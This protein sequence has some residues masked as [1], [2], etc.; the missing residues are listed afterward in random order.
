MAAYVLAHADDMPAR[1]ALSVLAPDGGSEDWNYDDLRRAVLG[2]AGALL[3]RG[4]QA[5]DRVLL[6][7]GNTVDFPICYLAALSVDI[8]PVPVSSQLTAA[9]LA[10]ILDEIAPVAILAD[11][12]LALPPTDGPVLTEEMLREMRGADPAVP[13]MGDPDRLGYIIY[14]SGTSGRPRAVMHAH[15]AVWA[16]RMMHADWCGLGPDDRLLHAGAFNWTY[17]LGTGLMDPWTVGATALIPAEG[18]P[19]TALPTLLAR[20]GATIFAAAPGVFRKLLKD[21]G[22]LDLP[23]LRH[24][25]SAGEK[26]PPA[27]ARAWQQATG[28]PIYEALGMSECSTFISTGPERPAAPDSSGLP[29]RG[30]RVAVVDEAGQ[31]LPRRTPGILA[32]DRD[33]PGMM[34]GYLGQPAETRDRFR[35]QWFLTGDTVLMEDC[36]SVRYLGR[37]D[38]MMN[39]GGYRVSPLEVEAAMSAH[40]AILEAAAFEAQVRA[41]ASVIALCYTCPPD[42]EAP[43]DDTLAAFAAERLAR[44]KCPRIF[45]RID[46]MPVNANGK[47]NRRALREDRKASQ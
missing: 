17:T 32:V 36:G 4:F 7:L 23:A 24:G 11:S 38:D 6:R 20:H 44:Y 2:T 27:T 1:L 3:A 25:L 22:P 40:P 18:T 12:R 28:T 14:T 47:I 45:R 13:V 8:V 39:A 15:R 29:Q 19:I 10:P 41:D 5:G 42:V 30:R 43:E 35:G 16:R 37:D 46:T 31:P 21:G 26:L 33:D 34:L 9:E